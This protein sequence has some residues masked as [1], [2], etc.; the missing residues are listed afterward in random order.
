MRSCGRWSWLCSGLVTI[1]CSVVGAT[2]MADAPPPVRWRNATATPAAALTTANS[3]GL[4]AGAG[5]RHLVVQFA[6]MPSPE[7]RASLEAD[8]LTLLTYLGSNAFFA[9]TSGQAGLTTS[10]QTAGLTGVADPQLDWK[11]HPMLLRGEAPAYSKFA[12]ATGASPKDSLTLA[13]PTQDYVALY[14]IFQPDVDLQTSGAAALTRHGGKIRDYIYSINGVVAWLPANNIQ[15][16]TMEDDVQWVEPPLPPF[17]VNNDSNRI[18]TQADIVQAAPYNLTGSGVKVLVYDGGTALG[19]HADFGGR[20]IV[21]DNSGTGDHPTHVSGTIG[22]SGVSSGGV[23]RGM[24]PAV[25]LESYGFQYDGTGSFLYTNPGDMEQDYTQA[26][27]TYGAMISNNSIGTNTAPNGFP[28]EWEGDYGATDMLI[29][30]MVRGSLGSPM[31]I[32]W[33]NGNERGSGRCGTTYHTTAP[34]A[35]AKN[36]ITVGALNS[37]D[38]SITTF[39]SW[40]PSDDGRIKPDISAPGCQS[41]GDGGVTSAVSNGGYGVMCGT[42]MA[43]PTVTGLC[44]L[45][46]EDYMAQFPATALP[47]NS[48]LKVLLAQ[49]AVDLGTVGPD[50]KFG[51]G[52]VRVQDTIDGMR[53]HSFLEASIDHGQQ[54][55]FFVNVP[56][57]AAQLKATVAWD[58]PP[59]SANVIPELVNDLDILAVGP[60]GTT[61]GYPWTLDPANPS[62]AAVRSSADHANNIEQ[63]VVDTPAEGVWQIRI[64]GYA[65]PSGPQVF[66]LAT[67]PDVQSCSSSGVISLSAL[68]YPCSATARVTVVDC[69][70]NANTGVAETLSVNVQSTSE[71]AGESL[72]L[73]ETGPNS[74]VFTATIGLSGTNAPGVL[75]IVDGDTVTGTYVDA[76]DGQGHTNVTVTSTSTVDCLGPVISNVSISAVGAVSATI[77]FTTSEPARGKVRYGTACGQLT[78]SVNDAAFTTAHTIKLV[79]LSPSTPYYL[80]IEANDEVGNLGSDTNGGTCY[81]FTTTARRTYWTEQFNGTTNRFDLT[82]KSILYIPDGSPD[83]YQVCV[84]IGTA[85]PVDPTGSTALSLDDDSFQQVTLTSGKKVSLYGVQ[86]GSA[87]VGS[88]GYLTFTA[89]DRSYS[90]APATHFAFPRVSAFFDDLNPPAGTVVWKQTADALVVTWQAVPEFSLTTTNTFQAVMYFDGAILLAWTAMAAQDGMVGLSAGTGLADDYQ[91][92]DLT[93]LSG[94]AY[95]PTAAR[96]PSPAHGAVNA[97][98][99]PTLTWAAGY[100]T[101]SHDVYLGLAPNALQLVST[102]T[103]TSFAPARLASLTHYYWRVDEVNAFGTTTG[104]V[105]EF[106]T[107]SVPAD[108]DVDGDVDIEDY[109]LLQACLSGANVAQLLPACVPAH[110]D[111]DTDVDVEDNQRFRNCFSGPTVHADSN[112][113][114]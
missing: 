40:G 8:G 30:A 63:V 94:C 106:T 64:T 27:N 2:A 36:H 1:G 26:V 33:A 100:R 35:C 98:Y 19:T 34:P 54:K 14:V 99:T 80:A 92:F 69:D 81:P 62:L 46:L 43:A 66:S 96:T 25:T 60:D 52:S 55:I 101:V 21:R 18:I 4:L 31:R 84:D 45:I 59:G 83:F 65:V 10:V 72:L 70:L 28:C 22:G 11:L 48:T 79:G 87:Y 39:S 95:A 50:Y 76:N 53:L 89:G 113:T 9:R 82:G 24:A 90:E 88:N 7:T 12:V 104:D 102:Q 3:A 103:S 107:R 93:T 51:Y 16:F 97:S 42:S 86:Y 15:A 49:Y 61:I 112:C 6:K 23:Y 110:L 32:V 91:S 67:T 108:F 56:A 13:A 37:N 68:R 17:D 5:P 41:N 114:P 20:L 73:T 77:T 85:L 44:A 58:D 78:T 74:A 47:R 75:Q 38:D 109:G 57:G 71:P 105:W 111:A 29:D